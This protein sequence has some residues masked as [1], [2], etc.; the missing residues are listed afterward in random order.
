M[1]FYSEAIFPILNDAATYPLRRY[2]MKTLQGTSGT[3]LEIGFGSGASVPY[4]P[5]DVHEIVGLEPNAGMLSRAAGIRDPRVRLVSGRAEALPFQ[6]H[7]FDHVVSILTLCTVTH[8][9]QTL[10]E[11]QRVL[12]PGGQ[13]HFLEHIASPH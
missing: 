3:V 6:E 13:L 5:P 8:L 1:S 2:R 4:Y 7:T 11:I 9:S 10:L 12:K